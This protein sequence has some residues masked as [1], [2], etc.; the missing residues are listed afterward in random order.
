ML[1]I[2]VPFHRKKPTKKQNFYI[3]IR[4][5]YFSNGWGLLDHPPKRG[6]KKSPVVRSFEMLNPKRV[7]SKRPYR[8]QTGWL[9]GR[10]RVIIRIMIFSKSKKQL[11]SWNSPP[12]RII[13]FLVGNPYKPSL[14]TVTGWGVDRTHK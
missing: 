2:P 10:C 14:V 5:R 11:I 12:T 6:A 13:P 1:R 8:M 4:S 9:S 3:S 7:S